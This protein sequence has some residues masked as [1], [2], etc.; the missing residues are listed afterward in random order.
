M[1][2]VRNIRLRKNKGNDKQIFSVL[3]RKKVGKP[4]EQY[5]YE[6]F[7]SLREAIRARDSA[8]KYGTRRKKEFTGIIYNEEG[9]KLLRCPEHPNYTFPYVPEHR[10]VMEDY[11]GRYL[12]DDEVVHHKNRVKDD[13]RIENLE[14]L[15]RS[16]HSSLHW[17][18]DGNWM[19]K[20]FDMELVKELYL[21]GLSCRDVAKEI[22]A[23]KTM[24]AKYVKEMGISRP[25]MTIKRDAYGNFCK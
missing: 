14:L 21:S 9:Y 10:L 15:K 5:Y 7:Y 19:K 23:G 17:E 1:R 8:H 25:Q 20:Q 24:V 2:I 12:K 11:L 3:V 18:E 16:E 13:N 4:D 6:E 22:G